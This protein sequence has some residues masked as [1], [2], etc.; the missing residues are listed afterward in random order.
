VRLARGPAAFAIS[1]LA[2]FARAEEPESTQPTD[3]TSINVEI[4]STAIVLPAPPGWVELTANRDAFRE[5]I[6]AGI[7]AD[8][9]H[10]GTFGTVEVANDLDAARGMSEWATAFTI[11]AQ[12]EKGVSA[13]EFL[14]IRLATRHQW[15][16]IIKG[17]QE[18]VDEEVR[19][20]SERMQEKLGTDV[21]LGIGEL[22]TPGVFLDEPGAVGGLLTA[23]SQTVVGDETTS[24]DMAMALIMLHVRSHVVVLSAYRD[25]ASPS[26]FEAVKT[27]ALRWMDAVRAANPEPAQPAM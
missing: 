25:K 26:D 2:A 15:E 17:T 22:S 4:G 24:F 9:R 19:K 14:A 12:E 13:S 27:V 6:E 21:E 23:A 16:E 18:Y 3:P 1:L 10:L 20:S 7:P 11:R 8:G 5:L